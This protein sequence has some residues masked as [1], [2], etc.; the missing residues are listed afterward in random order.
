M[1]ETS[2]YAYYAFGYN[3]YLVRFALSGDTHKLVVKRLEAYLTKITTLELQVTSK[4]VSPLHAIVATLKAQKP[5]DIIS[6]EDV[7][8]IKKIIDSADKTLDAELQMKKVLS[9]TP[10][11]FDVGM[12]LERPQDLL[13]NGCCDLLAENCKKDFAEATRCIAMNLPTAAAFHLMRCVEEAVK[14]LYYEYVKNNRLDKPMWGPMIDKLKNKKRPKPSDEL[15][16]QLDII[17]KNFRNP[18]QH[19]DKFYNSDGAQDL[20]N[21]S[22]VALNGVC[23][24]ITKKRNK[25]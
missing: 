19:P 1:K 16:D 20:L 8:K 23:H 2:I 3:Y 22:I 24:Q 10:K 18:T 15:L 5:D 6:Q 17:R 11:R 21:S 12:L 4:V 9:V 13:A 7:T 25:A 14:M